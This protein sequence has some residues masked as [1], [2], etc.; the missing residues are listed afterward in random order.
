MDLHSLSEGIGPS[1]TCRCLIHSPWSQPV[2]IISDEAVSDDGVWDQVD[3]HGMWYEAL[4]GCGPA[5][6]GA[7]DIVFGGREEIPL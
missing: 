3:R 5:H 1:D 4:E 2:F 6:G 7:E